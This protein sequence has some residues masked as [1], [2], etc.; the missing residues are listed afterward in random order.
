M[1]LNK[2]LARKFIPLGDSLRDLLTKFGLRPYKVRIVRIRWSGGRRGIGTAVVE[3][4]LDILPTPKV[5]DLSTLTEIVNPVGL[6]EVGIILVTQISGR[7]TDEDLRFLDND[8]GDQDPD[9]EV[10]Y[11]IEFPRSDGRPGDKRRFFLRSAPMY[12][13]GKLQW[14]LRLER[15]HEDR[16]RNGD[17]PE[18]LPMRRGN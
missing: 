13:A 15:A 7:F 3:K 4:A 8:G 2:T 17:P 5:L 14:Q 18:Y 12:M 16:E 11:E 6:D 10:F 9:S 1:Q